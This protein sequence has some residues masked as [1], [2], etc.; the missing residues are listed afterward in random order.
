[1][2]IELGA[3]IELSSMDTV[4]IASDGLYD[5]LSKDE[6]IEL[7]RA[8]SIEEATQALVD[9]CLDRMANPQASRPTKP[10]DL[11]VLVYR[12]EAD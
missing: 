10:D 12:P 3:V 7:V 2:T 1:M 6:I 5:N 4:V 9:T 8:G 11:T